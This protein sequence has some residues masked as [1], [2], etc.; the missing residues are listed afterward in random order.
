MTECKSQRRLL[1]LAGFSVDATQPLA[2]FKEVETET[3]FPL[4]LNLDDV[5]AVTVEMIANRLPGRGEKRDILDY[6]LE[7]KN[8]M[9]SD[10]TIDGVAE[11]GYSS[12]IIFDGI[13]G[14]FSINVEIVTALLAAVRFKMPVNVAE[15]ALA[16]SALIDQR[17]FATFADNDPATLKDIL[18]KLNPEDMGKY[19]M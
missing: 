2:L 14:S 1:N 6:L 12:R 8:M 10:I 9:V 4:W 5:I 3:T 17:E 15:S 11:T 13:S 18:D 19:P 7:A 16:S